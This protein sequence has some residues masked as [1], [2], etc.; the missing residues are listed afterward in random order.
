M[1]YKRTQ[2]RYAECNYEKAAMNAWVDLFYLC[3][4]L[5]YEKVLYDRHD[6]KDLLINAKIPLHCM[7]R[8]VPIDPTLPLRPRNLAILTH[9]NANLLIKI[10]TQCCSV[11]QYVMFV[12]ACNLLP[13]NADVG[14]PGDPFHDPSY[15]RVD[16]DIIPLLQK[17]KNMPV[18][19]PHF[20]AV[21]D[22]TLSED[23]VIEKVK[24]K[25]TT[26]TASI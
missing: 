3:P 22:T 4:I 24:R 26:T 12:Q 6:I 9:H 5:G 25:K 15:L 19:R 16:M 17:E 8:V 10:Y 20:D 18:E 23:E 13:A 7:P 11:A 14:V 1:V 2:Q 21:Y